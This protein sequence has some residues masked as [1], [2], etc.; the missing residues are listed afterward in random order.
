MTRCL[1][2]PGLRYSEVVNLRLEDINWGKGGTISF[3][4][5]KGRRADV[6]PL[7][8]ATGSAIAAYLREERPQTLNR[9]IFVRH[10]VPYDEP[11]E[12]GVVARAVWQAIEDA[13][14]PA[15]GSIFCGT[16]SPV[17]FCAPAHR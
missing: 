8:T 14:G 9:A 16:V 1:I 15:Q 5:T 4:R 13:D 2:D 11:I 6:L 7:P 3:C 12:K 17:G 10:V